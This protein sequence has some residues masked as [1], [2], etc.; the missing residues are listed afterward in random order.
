MDA[1]AGQDRRKFP[2]LWGSML[3]P[4]FYGNYDIQ[5]RAPLSL[6]PAPT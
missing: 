5:F 4:P 3:G 6:N 1:G 2:E